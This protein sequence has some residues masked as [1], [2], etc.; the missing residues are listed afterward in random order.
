MDESLKLS[1]TV[2][3]GTIG[4]MVSGFNG[5][6]FTGTC[7]SECSLLAYGGEYCCD[8]FPF[9]LACAANGR[10]PRCGVLVGNCCT[11]LIVH[12][13]GNGGLSHIVV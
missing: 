6:S 9:G 4:L 5:G 3:T 12:D 2:G 11:I 7:A 1:P 8:V 10:V 13:G